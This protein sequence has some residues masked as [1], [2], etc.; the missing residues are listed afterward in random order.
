MHRSREIQQRQLKVRHDIEKVYVKSSASWA[1]ST[2]T[3]RFD[4][5]KEIQERDEAI[6]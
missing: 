2:A 1:A 3:K 4:L 6:N 5:Y